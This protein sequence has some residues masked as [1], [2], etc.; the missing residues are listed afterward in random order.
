MP[1]F[2]SHLSFQPVLLG[3]V[4]LEHFSTFL[5]RSQLVLYFVFC[6]FSSYFLPFLFVTFPF[7]S[8]LFFLNAMLCLSA[9]FKKKKYLRQLFYKLLF[10]LQQKA[11][12]SFLH[13]TAFSI[14][15]FFLDIFL[16]IALFFLYK[17]LFLFLFSF[18]DVF[19]SH[20]CILKWL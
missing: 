6:F 2:F 14:S 20:F 12:F 15:A 13:F 17:S 5:L 16:P 3:D 18:E 7:L 4:R 1:A 19:E 11:L 9:R 8:I 10:F